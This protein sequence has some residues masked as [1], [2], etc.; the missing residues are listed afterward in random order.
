MLSFLRRTRSD[1]HVV[2]IDDI[3]R[4]ARGMEAHL[5]LRNDIDRAGG[6]LQSPSIEFG[7]DSDSILVEHLLATVAQHQLQKNSEQTK[8]RMR[9]RVQYGY[10]AWKAPIG[11]MSEFT[12]GHGL[13]L[14]RDEPLASIVKEGL[15]GFANRRFETQAEV[16]RF[17]ESQPLFPRNKKGIVRNQKVKDMLTQPLYAGL[18]DLPKWDITLQRAKHEALIS[19]DTYKQIQERLTGK[20]KAPARKD[21]NE[22]F[23]LRGFVTCGH[24]GTPMTACWSKGR[25]A[26]YP[27]YLCPNRGCEVYGK[28]VRR[29][30]MEEQ[31]TDL[32]GALQPSEALFDL[33]HKMFC[34][35]WDA[36]LTQAKTH[37]KAM[38]SELTKIDRQVDQFFDRIVENE[39]TTMLAAYE[40]RIRSLESRKIELEE[41]ISACGRPLQGVDETFRTAMS[42]L[43]NP[44]NLWHSERLED[45]RAVLRLAFADRL[46]YWR[47]E[48][49][50]T[51]RIS[52]PFSVLKELEG[53]ESKMA[54]P[55][56]FEPLT[57]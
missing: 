33:A 48:G 53:G 49:F 47:G 41:K 38:Q 39:S 12:L 2:I 55:K 25:T 42:F 51:A 32:L 11:Y 3:S 57:S 20:A 56:G 36:R 8:H 29:E 18:I 19:Y 45:K 22:D 14:V 28:S 17:F 27:Y 16:K 54:R 15:E 23:P 40:K 6:I 26:R 10:W 13:L 21:L 43:G 50:R 5:K 34:D 24:C 35:L 4:L 9:A 44:Q 52:L 37:T 1:P 30:T 7:E 31:F 46:P